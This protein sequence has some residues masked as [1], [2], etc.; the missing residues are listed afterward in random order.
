M[1]DILP[2]QSFN[3]T[4]TLKP[5]ANRLGFIKPPSYLLHD[6]M[7]ISAWSSFIAS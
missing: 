3:L 1:K 6:L 7:Q 2:M 5:E 4:R